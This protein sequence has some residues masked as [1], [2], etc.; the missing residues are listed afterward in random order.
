MKKVLFVATV[1]NFF[2]F[3]K[4]DMDILEDFGYEVHCAANFY[5]G[6][7]GLN[8][9]DNRILH[10][11]DFNRSPYSKQT[12]VAYRQLKALLSTEHFD[13]IHC[14]TPVGGILTRLAARQYRNYGTKVVYTA[15]GFHFYKGCPFKNWIF[16]YSIEKLC[17]RWTD[18]LITI[19]TDDYKIAK[20]KLLAKK[21]TYIP[22][23]GI[24]L[25][26]F[27]YSNEV[28]IKKRTELG[29]NNEIMFLSVG[30]LSE[31]KNHRAV[32]NVLKQLKDDNF[33]Y[34]IVGEGSLD[35]EL[36]NLINSV[37]LENKVF[38]LG[39]RRD[40]AELCNAADIYLFPSFQEGLPVALM[41]AIAC[42]CPV[43]VSD[44]R[45]NRDLVKNS[46][47]R[48]PVLSESEK[49]YDLLEKN[50]RQ[51][52]RNSWKKEIEDN[53]NVLNAFS[54]Q[55]VQEKMRVLYKELCK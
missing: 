2:N 20:D 46:E 41:E 5:D 6:D 23:V 4:S 43:I 29:L 15:H 37:G 21:V 11:I 35:K 34:F 18:L 22:G 31:R 36:K 16:Y 50:I 38:L 10:Q 45:G 19:N 52:N 49:L 17:S 39:F 14:H 1:G 24:D 7:S 51:F 30:E 42:K 33:K 55:A 8:E 25:E 44:I 28:R 9:T 48:F 3:E 32:I 47:F 40:V 12:I 54:K 27:S 26:K 13:I 53:Y